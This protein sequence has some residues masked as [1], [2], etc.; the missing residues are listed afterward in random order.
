[1]FSKGVCC[2]SKLVDKGFR[3]RI[4]PN[5]AQQ[6]LFA[7]NFGCCRFVFNH[8]LAKAKEEHEAGVKFKSAYDRQKEL[9][10]L[11]RVEEFK[12][13][14]EADSSSLNQAVVNLTNAYSKFFAKL[15][16]FPRFKKKSYAQSYMTFACSGTNYLHVKDSKICIPK[17]GWVKIKQH[18]PLEGRV[19][20]GTISKT[21]SGKYFISLHCKNCEVNS[22]PKTGK[23]IGIDLGVK[24]YL[25]DQFGNE[26]ENPK[27]LKKSLKRLAIQQQKL[28]RKKKKSKNFQKQRI[29]VAKLYEKIHNQRQDFLH[30]LS[31]EIVK[32]H[33][34]IAA[35]KLDIKAMLQEKDE[36]LTN[37]QNQAIHR[38]QADVS[39]YEFLRQLQYKSDWYGKTFVRVNTYFPSSQLCNCCGYKNPEVKNLDIRKWTC[40]CCG[41]THLRDQNAA[42]NILKEAKRIAI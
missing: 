33:D 4:Y 28:A 29:R 19:T 14:K 3:F 22:L 41:T 13:L 36:K 24:T 37:S 21:A 8:F 15:A 18:R 42:I 25:T 5:K 9:T 11:K 2:M 31:A 23:E 7:K 40:P 27:H 6:V 32:N 38:S 10:A 16:D 30:K 1:M 17:I 34:F 12:F 20:S 39:Q 26:V 35:E